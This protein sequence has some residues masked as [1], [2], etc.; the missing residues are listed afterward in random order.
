MTPVTLRTPGH[1]GTCLRYP[2]NHIAVFAAIYVG[3]I[4]CK[5]EQHHLGSESKWVDKHRRLR[6]QMKLSPTY[7][8]W[9]R[10]PASG[11]RRPPL[12]TGV[13]AN[14][15]FADVINIAWA[16]R[17]IERR[18]LPFF[19]NYTQRPTRTP[20]GTSIKT[21]TTSSRVYDYGRDRT[22]TPAEALLLHG[23]PVLE[24]DLSMF[25]ASSLFH[26]VGESMCCPCVGSLLLA[27]YLN[28]HG[29]WWKRR[30]AELASLST[31]SAA[32]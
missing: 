8:P 15:R 3:C 7:S 1:P 30:A 31:G 25:S 9:T 11:A 6:T 23:H 4:L 12:L 26:S 18:T 24:M 16:S 19:C 29:A 2:T 13:P 21:L 17:P 5:E 14:R 20:W 22:I 32:V 27:F 10:P 28:P